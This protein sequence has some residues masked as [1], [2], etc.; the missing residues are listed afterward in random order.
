MRQASVRLVLFVLVTVCAVFPAA[1]KEEIELHFSFSKSHILLGEPVWIVVTAKN[2]SDHLIAVSMGSP[3]W[4]LPISIEVAGAKPGTGERQVCAYGYGGSCMSS[5]PP[6]LLPGEILTERYL[7][8]QRLQQ[9]GLHLESAGEYTVRVHKDVQ[10]GSPAQPAITFQDATSYTVT[11]DEELNLTISPPDPKRLAEVEQN[12]AKT[13][14]L[15]G[16][17][18]W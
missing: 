11:G 12:L 8:Q 9:D 3:C 15:G 6:R 7:L 16:T 14:V 4:E 5:P 1:A 10:Y 13:I 2:V 17:Q 18:D